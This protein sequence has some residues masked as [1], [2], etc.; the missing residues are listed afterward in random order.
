GS[1][2]LPVYKPRPYG[3][4][5]WLDQQ[6]RRCFHCRYKSQ[7]ARKENIGKPNLKYAEIRNDGYIEGVDRTYRQ[8]EREAKYESEQV[9]NNARPHTRPRIARV[10]PTPPQACNRKCPRDP[11]AN[12]DSV[13]QREIRRGPRRGSASVQQ[14]PPPAYSRPNHRHIDRPK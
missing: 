2:P 1:W 8:R 10:A 12:R 11:G 9:T 6:E 3:I 5:D 13:A 14:Q 7:R 4:E